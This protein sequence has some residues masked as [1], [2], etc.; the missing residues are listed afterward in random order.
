MAL[1]SECNDPFE[2][3]PRSRVTITREYMLE[4]LQRDPEHFRPAYDDLVREGFSQLFSEFLKSL[5]EA[6]E[7]MFP[8]FRIRYRDR[9]I[10]LDLASREQASQF[11]GILCLSLPNLSIPMWSHYGHEHSG[12]VI[13]VKK[14]DPAFSH[15]VSGWVRYR[16]NRVSV[17]PLVRPGSEVWWKQINRTI[18]SK[19][20]EWSYEKELESFFV[21]RS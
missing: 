4:K 8:E 7:T 18:F 14:D 12:V 2:F 11:V 13:G 9:L 19:S 21:C 15:G 5:P 1:P 3:T 16:K 10:D 20:P 17:D 6:I